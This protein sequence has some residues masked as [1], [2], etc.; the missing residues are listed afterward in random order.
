MRKSWPAVKKKRNNM[1]E[2]LTTT[3]IVNIRELVV[4][5]RVCR[6]KGQGDPLF[7]VALFG[8]PGEL[9]PSDHSGTV[10]C[11]FEGNPG[12]VLEFNIDEIDKILE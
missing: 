12:D 4:G 7:V 1:V 3:P 8:D 10:Y 11:D 6:K 9:I 5:D 2:K